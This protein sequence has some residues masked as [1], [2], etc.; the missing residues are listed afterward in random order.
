MSDTYT[1]KT[2]IRLTL[3]NLRFKSVLA[4]ANLSY[5]CVGCTLDFDEFQPYTDPSGYERDRPVVPDL[6][7]DQDPIMNDMLPQDDML[8][9]EDMLPPVLDGDMDGILD[10]EDNCPMVPNPDQAD[11]DMDNRGDACDDDD[12]REDICH[13]SQGIL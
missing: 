6:G 8:P 5:L 11:G 2:S 12:G 7:P 1:L 13:E 9:Q 10:D 3:N 4:L